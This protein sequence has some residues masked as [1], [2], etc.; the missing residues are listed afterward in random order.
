MLQDEIALFGQEILDATRNRDCCSPRQ[1]DVSQRHLLV[2]GEIE[3][4]IDGHN[5]QSHQKAAPDASNACNES[6][7]TCARREISVTYSGHG[8]YDHVNSIIIGIQLELKRVILL[9]PIVR[10]L[11]YPHKIAEYKHSSAKHDGDR[12]LR[13]NLHLALKCESHIGAEPICLTEFL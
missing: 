4:I 8:D 3:D 2:V 9:L 7:E 10:Y 11:K 6:P 12:P 5:T 13:V 1:S